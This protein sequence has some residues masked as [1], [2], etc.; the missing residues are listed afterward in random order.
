MFALK[1][2]A[3]PDE[4]VR[5]AFDSLREPICVLDCDG[6]IVLTNQ[7]WNQSVRANG[8]E[9]ARCG[10]GVNYLRVC[11]AARGP[12]SE[13]AF[14]T[15]IGIE[16]VLLGAASQFSLDYPCPS[17]SRKAWFRLVARP[18][19]GPHSG[20]V[21]LHSAITD[22]VLL[23]EKLRRTQAHF[24]ALWQNPVHV[25]T[26]LAADGNVRYQSPASEGVLGIHP[27]DLVGR[28][29]FDFVHPN[30]SDAVRKLLR[31]CLRYP[32]RKHPAEYR[33]RDRD[34]SWRLLES[35]ATNLLSHPEG[36][37]ILSSRDITHQKLA[38]QILAAKQDALARD[39]REL[40]V[41][42][43]RL[44]REQED[45]RRLVAA[46]LN[47]NLSQRLAAMSLQAAHLASPAAG[48]GQSHALR[49]SIA[50]MGRELHCLARA[51]Y[52]AALDHFG[53]AV[54]LRDYCA[55]FTR[56]KGV[57]V[58]YVHR[59]ISARLPGH[60]AV[61]L[62]RIAEEALSNVARHAHANRAWVTLSRTVQGTRLAIRDDGA[63]FDPAGVELE[64]GLGILAMRERLLGLSA[65][66]SLSIRS[67]PGAGTEV[68]AVVP[69][70]APVQP[71]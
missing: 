52:P 45:E 61:T 30:D 6:W 9:P 3:E 69:L 4:L 22:R 39:R 51:Q 5:I 31:D 20:A 17:P 50:N 68:V 8:A 26:V 27:E 11:R 64:S 2:V 59:G 35:I 57:P 67:R 32:H 47:G 15:A 60:T 42:V 16:T 7:A 56:K 46:E 53:L 1:H 36:G 19:R 65:A 23:A 24:G 14:D 43:A 21:I 48:G 12:F 18:L 25:D 40:E 70:A 66:G 71:N 44:L 58:K 13:R 34:G 10:T 63:G 33:F 62:Y 54:A 29:I 28:P 41:L 38:E 49:E 55:E 37:I